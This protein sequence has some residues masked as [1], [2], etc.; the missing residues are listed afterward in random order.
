MPLKKA[1]ELWRDFQSVLKGTVPGSLP[2]PVESA[3]PTLRLMKQEGGRK[4]C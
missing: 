1:L 2:R 4:R 3:A